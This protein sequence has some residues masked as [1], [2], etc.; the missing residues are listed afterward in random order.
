MKLKQAS[1]FVMDGETL[2]IVFDALETDEI[3][4]CVQFILIGGSL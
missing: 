2:K 1:M 3:D 4:R